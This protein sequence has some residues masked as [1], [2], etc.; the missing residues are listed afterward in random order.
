MND[1][2]LNPSLSFLELAKARNWFPLIVNCSTSVAPLVGRSWYFER[3]YWKNLEG[4]N[5][6]SIKR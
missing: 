6:I 3:N 2:V 5:K 1:S 4:K